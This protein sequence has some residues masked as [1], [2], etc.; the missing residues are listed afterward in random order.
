M[1]VQERMIL[2]ADKFSRLAEEMDLTRGEVASLACFL[3]AIEISMDSDLEGS[4]KQIFVLIESLL[5]D[6]ILLQ[7][8]S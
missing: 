2:V 4:K 3:L 1:E 8:E 7:K 6:Q 5:K